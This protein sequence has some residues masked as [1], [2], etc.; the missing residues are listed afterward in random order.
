MGQTDT[1]KEH[2]TIPSP[3]DIFRACDHAGPRDAELKRSTTGETLRAC[4]QCGNAAIGAHRAMRKAQLA[5]RP[6]DCARCG[7]KPHTYTWGGYRLC[8]ACLRVTR[9]EHQAN[10]AKAGVFALF[11][12]GAMISTAGWACRV[13]TS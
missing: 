7:R 11:A 5:A 13:E 3:E 1:T 6:K 10:A 2:G 9:A 8:G 12:T 4:W